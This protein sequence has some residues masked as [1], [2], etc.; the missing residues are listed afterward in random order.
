MIAID[1][2]ELYIPVFVYNKLMLRLPSNNL[3]MFQVILF[4][5]LIS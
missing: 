5:N 3:T 4:I 2:L 1:F